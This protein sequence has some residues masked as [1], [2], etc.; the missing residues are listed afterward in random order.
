MKLT[1]RKKAFG[2][3]EVLLAGVIIIIVLSSLVVVAR[4]ALDNSVLLQQR[5]QATYLAQ[6]GIE[7]VRQIRDTNYIDGDNKTKW[8]TLEGTDSAVVISTNSNTKYAVKGDMSAGRVRLVLYNGQED[9]V[10]SIDGT[11]FIRTIKFD[12]N[13]DG[14]LQQDPKLKYNGSQ[15]TTQSFS[16]E[17]EVSWQ[18]KNSEQR[19]TI[20]IREMLTNSRQGF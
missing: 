18:S 11:D 13:Y 5:A 2:L 1:K 4:N 9:G 17:V 10:V 7:L 14:S 3:L 19:K 12:D 20:M 16:V 6:E 15:V 8:N